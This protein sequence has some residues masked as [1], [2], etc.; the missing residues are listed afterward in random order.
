MLFGV[1]VAL[2]LPS[3]WDQFSFLTLSQFT[4][5]DSHGVAKFS[6]GRITFFFIRYVAPAVLIFKVK[7]VCGGSRLRLLRRR[8]AADPK[9]FSSC[10]RSEIRWVFFW[11]Q[12]FLGENSFVFFN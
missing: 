4:Q 3:H 6:A 7:R 12:S 5:A 1:I 11:P 9:G 2:L 10:A 8:T